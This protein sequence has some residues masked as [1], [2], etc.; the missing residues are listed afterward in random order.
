LA[1]FWQTRGQP[2]KHRSF[3]SI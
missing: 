2:A 1:V 3:M